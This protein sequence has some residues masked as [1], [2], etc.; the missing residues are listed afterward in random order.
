MAEVTLKASADQEVPDRKM[1]ETELAS[2][3]ITQ[4]WADI[5]IFARYMFRGR[6]KCLTSKKHNELRMARDDGYRVAYNNALSAIRFLASP[7]EEEERAFWCEILE[8]SPKVLTEFTEMTY[9]YFVEQMI[10]APAHSTVENP[11]MELVW[12]ARHRVL[13]A[14]QI[15]E[16]HG[17]GGRRAKDKRSV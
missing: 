12:K 6:V 5:E 16:P 2:A 17:K 13:R 9:P 8:V 3:I 14:K 1:D 15:E 11:Y 7:E 4:C 10:H